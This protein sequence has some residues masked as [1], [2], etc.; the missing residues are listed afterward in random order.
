[1]YIKGYS[2]YYHVNVANIY[3]ISSSTS[4]QKV[5]SYTYEENLMRAN[6]DIKK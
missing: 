3:F 6:V 2:L 5:L 1:M 4:W